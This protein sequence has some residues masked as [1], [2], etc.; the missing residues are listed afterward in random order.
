M[1]ALLQLTEGLPGPGVAINRCSHRPRSASRAL[2]VLLHHRP[3]A[4]R[5]CAAAASRSSRSRCRSSAQRSA[6]SPAYLQ[7]EARGGCQGSGLGMEWHDARLAGCER[8]NSGVRRLHLRAA[9]Q[10]P[11]P[12]YVVSVLV[13]PTAQQPSTPAA[14]PHL[15]L[16]TFSS[17]RRRT[18]PLYTPF[19]RHWGHVTDA[20]T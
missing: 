17:W 16:S 13:S 20:G 5:C 14:A 18:A 19:C 8:D 1:H 7:G 9:H 15:V 6:Q 10:L 2:M 11:A 12:I 4:A 3:A